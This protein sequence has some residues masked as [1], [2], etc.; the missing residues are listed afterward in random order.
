MNVNT[1]WSVHRVGDDTVVYEQ[2]HTY[3]GNVRVEFQN[4]NGEIV[5]TRGADYA[6]QSIADHAASILK[7]A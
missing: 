2:N 7:G 3:A 4:K 5:C 6:H 1:S